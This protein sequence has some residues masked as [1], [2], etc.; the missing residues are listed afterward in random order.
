MPTTASWRKNMREIR[1]LD[2]AGVPRAEI[3]RRHN[4]PR[5]VITKALGPRKKPPGEAKEHH[6]YCRPESFRDVADQVKEEFGFTNRG[7]PKPGEGNIGKLIDAIANGEVVLVP[8][9][10]AV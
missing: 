3:A 9:G 8:V 1:E 4:V 2:E 7:G 10:D 6:V 5:Q